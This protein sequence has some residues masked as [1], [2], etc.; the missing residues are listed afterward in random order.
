MKK[1]Y[2]DQINLSSNGHYA[3]PDLTYDWATNLG[4]MYRYYTYGVA[5]TEVEIDTLTG[6]HIVLRSD[7]V[8]D[9]GRSLNPAIDIGQIEG[10]FIQGQGWCTI[11]EP[12]FSPTTGFCNSKLSLNLVMTRGPGLYKI[13]GF[14]DIPVDFRVQLVKGVRNDKAVHSSKGIGEPP[15]FLGGSVYWA[16]KDAILDAR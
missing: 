5:C 8:M 9:V 6:D 4:R 13:P 3:S 7:V 10:A 1:A 12:L 15:L 16:I 2:L 14:K 11:E